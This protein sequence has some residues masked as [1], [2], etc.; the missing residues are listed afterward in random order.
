MLFFTTYETTRYHLFTYFGLDPNRSKSNEAA[1]AAAVPTQSMVTNTL[2]EAG[3][4]VV[5]GGLAGVAVSMSYHPLLLL[6][7][8]YSLSRRGWW[9]VNSS[10]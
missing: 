6:L 3:I 9:S 4:G 1:A 8:P 7:F 10:Q 5:T 2:L